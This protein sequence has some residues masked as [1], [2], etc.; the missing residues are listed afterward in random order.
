MSSYNSL[1]FDLCACLLAFVSV[2]RGHVK[3]ELNLGSIRFR[4]VL[5]KLPIDVVITSTLAQYHFGVG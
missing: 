3:R 2:Y 4:N 5:P 1:R